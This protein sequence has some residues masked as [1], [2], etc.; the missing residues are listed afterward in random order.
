MKVLEKLPADVLIYIQNVRKFF[1]SNVETRK[2]FDIDNN[3]DEFFDYVIE[4]AQKNYEENGVPELSVEQFEEL[5]LKTL[6]E[7]D[8]IGTFV[9][10]GNF[11]LISLN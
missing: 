8:M 4:L 10:L 7:P 5:K 3:E 2:Y 6:K 11:G 1:T 9:S